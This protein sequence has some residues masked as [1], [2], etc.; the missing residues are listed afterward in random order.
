MKLPITPLLE[1]GALIIGA[2]ILAVI[3]KG[4]RFQLP[5]A[6]ETSEGFYYKNTP[7]GR[8]ALDALMTS[9]LDKP[10]KEGE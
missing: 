6:F 7:K 4:K 2:S 10:E 8:A 9:K 5:D 3:I 1:I